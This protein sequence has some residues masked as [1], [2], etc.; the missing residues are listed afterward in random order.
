M[1]GVLLFF[2]RKLIAMGDI[3]FL[4]GFAF[5][6][7]F[8]RTIRCVPLPPQATPA[9]P[10]LSTR[11][12][13][14]APDLIPPP[15]PRRFFTRWERWRGIVTFLGG[16]LLVIFGWPVTGIFV[17]LFARVPIAVLC[18]IYQFAR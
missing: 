3:L 12:N 4:A 16:I 15:L 8:H 7:G 14:G 18:T 9:R 6:S 5:L 10:S 17:Q 11:C 1:P 2:D 13:G